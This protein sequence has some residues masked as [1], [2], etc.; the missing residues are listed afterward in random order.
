M[1]TVIAAAAMLLSTSLYAG[2]FAVTQDPDQYDGY[3]GSKTFPTAVQP[4][5]GDNWGSSFLYRT[6]FNK[7]QQ[8]DNL[9]SNDAYGSVILDVGH[10][11]DW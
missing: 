10:P 7:S 4:G 9:G 8:V 5:I 1:K 11:I 2:P 3:A 6:G